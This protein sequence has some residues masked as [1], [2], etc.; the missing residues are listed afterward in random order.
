MPTYY[1]DLFSPETYEGDA[2]P[3]PG[4]TPQMQFAWLPGALNQ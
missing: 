1:A 4:S 2:G 3:D